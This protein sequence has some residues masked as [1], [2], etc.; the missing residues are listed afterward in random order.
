MLQLLFYGDTLSK[1]ITNSYKEQR[2]KLQKIYDD[3]K[4][5]YGPT[6]SINSIFNNLPNPRDILYFASGNKEDLV[7]P[8]DDAAKTFNLATAELT[9]PAISTSQPLP[10]IAP[11]SGPPIYDEDLDKQSRYLL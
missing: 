4:L 8:Y 1:D 3:L 7:K 11:P 6:T 10:K 9:T 5:S 2:D